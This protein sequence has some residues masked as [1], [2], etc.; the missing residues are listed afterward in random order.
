MPAPAG[1]PTAARRDNTRPGGGRKGIDHEY[2]LHSDEG[3]GLAKPENRMRS[4]AAAEKFLAKHL[5]GRY[6]P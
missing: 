6:E 5:G 3:Q 4:A 1:S 2:L